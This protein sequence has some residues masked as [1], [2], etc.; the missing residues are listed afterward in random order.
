MSNVENE[1]IIENNVNNV[2]NIIM[3]ILNNEI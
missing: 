3:K 2:N 1:V